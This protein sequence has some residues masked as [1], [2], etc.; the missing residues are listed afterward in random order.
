M[1]QRSPNTRAEWEIEK[2]IF[3]KNIVFLGV[4]VLGFVTF[5]IS[6][7]KSSHSLGTQKI[8]KLAQTKTH[9]KGGKLQNYNELSKTKSY[10]L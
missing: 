3:D 4:S 6:K 9:L 10:N 8:Q 7:A 2:L 5:Q 1:G